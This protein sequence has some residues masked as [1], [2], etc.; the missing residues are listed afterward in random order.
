[1]LPVAMASNL[2]TAVVNELPFAPIPPDPEVMTKLLALMSVV[3]SPET[4]APVPP[5]VSVTLPPV[6]SRLPEVPNVMLVPFFV[7][8]LR[9]V[10]AVR[11]IASLIVIPPVFVLPIVI[12]PAVMRSSSGSVRSSPPIAVPRLI[13]WPAVAV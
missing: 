1:M 10:A 6:A 2:E 12:V 7:V 3:A 13:V 9:F 11:L 8:R 4:I 5:V